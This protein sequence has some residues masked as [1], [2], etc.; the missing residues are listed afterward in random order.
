MNFGGVGT[1]ALG[2]T[3]VLEA[4]ALSVL[5]SQSIRFFFFAQLFKYCLIKRRGISIVFLVVLASQFFRNTLNVLRMLILDGCCPV[6]TDCT[7]RRAQSPRF[8]FFFPGC[9]CFVSSGEC[10]MRLSL[11]RRDLIVPMYSLCR[12]CMALLRDSV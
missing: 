3:G 11:G 7:L 8:F 2:K 10:A 1:L 5:F 9:E 12:V 4:C 6:C